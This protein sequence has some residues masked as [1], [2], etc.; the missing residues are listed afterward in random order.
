MLTG[1]ISKVK[2]MVSKIHQINAATEKEHYTEEA[3]IINQYM[4]AGLFYVGDKEPFA[5]IETQAYLAYENT[6][7]EYYDVEP[8]LVFAS[9]ESRYSF[10]EFFNEY[11]FAN[12]VRNFQILLGQYVSMVR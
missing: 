12:V 7:V 5:S 11:D 1:N 6:H 10:D 9:D 2:E 4:D 8:V 3:S